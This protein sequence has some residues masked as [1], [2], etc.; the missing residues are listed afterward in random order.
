MSVERRIQI[1]LGGGD[2]IGAGDEAARR[3]LLNEPL[4][5]NIHSLYVRALCT[6]ARQSAC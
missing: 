5:D 4:A 3:F 6:A 2:C 1:V